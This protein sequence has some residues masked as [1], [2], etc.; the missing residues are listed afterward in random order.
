[1]IDE[2]HRSNLITHGRYERLRLLAERY[3]LGELSHHEYQRLKAETL[4][5]GVSD[6]SARHA[7]LELIVVTYTNLDQLERSL[8]ALRTLPTRRRAP[9]ID[10]A[11]A[12]KHDASDLRVQGISELTRPVRDDRASLIGAAC[13]LLAPLVWL[14][15]EHAGSRLEPSFSYLADLGINELDMR[16]FGATLPTRSASVLLLCWSSMADDVAAL[17][18]GFDRLTRRVLTEDVADALTILLI[19]DEDLR[20][21]GSPRPGW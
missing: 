11:L 9:V 18:H 15:A 12:T 13:G 1:M 7:Q 2:P 6:E 14:Q 19:D 20:S 8:N 17:F 10:A 16:S 4:A 5:G 21:P 3:E